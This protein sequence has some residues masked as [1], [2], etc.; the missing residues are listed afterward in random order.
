MSIVSSSGIL[1]NKDWMSNE[2]MYELVLLLRISFENENE[3]LTVYSLMVNSLSIG[4]KNFA[5]LYEQVTMAERTGRSGGNLLDSSGFW[6][7]LH[8]PYK[9]PGLLHLAS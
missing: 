6:G 2:A 8:N 5:K 4:T 7:T 1:V 9:I 3:S